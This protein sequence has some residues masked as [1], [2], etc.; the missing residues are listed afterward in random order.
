[1][2]TKSVLLPFLFAT[3]F[4]VFGASQAL[5]CKCSGPR[6][7]AGRNFQ[8]CT[9]FWNADVVFIGTVEKI[10]LEKAGTGDK[11]YYSRMVASFSVEKAIRG[12][13]EKTVEVETS[14]SSAICGYPFMEGERYFV[15]LK[16]GTDGK[17]TAHLCGPTVL[18]KNAQP[19]LEYLEAVEAGEKGG[20]V[21]GNV[22]RLVQAS[23]KDRALHTGL[24]GI[25]VR[26]N[27]VEVKDNT[28]KDKPKY[29]KRK[30]ETKTGDDGFYLFMEIPEG[31][32]TI[33]ADLSPNLR[34]LY[35]PGI[36][37]PFYVRFDSDRIRCGRANF[38]VTSLA[39][40]E[41]RVIKQDGSVPQQYMWLIPIDENGKARLDSYTPFTWIIGK[42]GRYYFD[43]VAPGKYLL[44]VNPKNC[45]TREAP[46]Y[47]RTF[48]PGVTDESDAKAVTVTE[49]VRTK[50]PDFK[51]S[52]PLNERVL[53][54]VV[55]STDNNPVSGVRVIMK[56]GGKTG[57]T[58]VDAQK[59]FVTDASGRFELKGFEGY[60]YM[61]RAYLETRAVKSGRLFSDMVEIPALKEPMANIQLILKNSY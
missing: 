45:H 40:L 26:L 5:A 30:F 3:V 20:R 24:G 53:S 47:G 46:Q 48:Y 55:L 9:V 49:N 31:N 59:E 38:L 17:F 54:G 36:E 23:F 10:S 22:S 42:E 61:L 58:N 15:Y 28:K 4:I 13:N 27:S 12:V 43:T 34:P 25:N 7:G 50:V 37:P 57:C 18:L 39:P 51:L 8:P 32:Y 1:M 41:G 16:R 33:E 56:T 11:A 21:F 2:R 52:P 19:D 35:R 29:V 44:A 14:P 6:T 60:E